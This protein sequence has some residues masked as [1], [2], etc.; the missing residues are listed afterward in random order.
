MQGAIQR[1]HIRSLLLGHHYGFLQSFLGDPYPVS[2]QSC[3]SFFEEFQDF[4]V[5][6]YTPCP[7]ACNLDAF[8]P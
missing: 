1:D 6:L 2:S 8:Q 3:Q 7:C 5:L 4:D